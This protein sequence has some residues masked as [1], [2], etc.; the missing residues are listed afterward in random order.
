MKL[1]K[2]S[3]CAE[4][5][6]DKGDFAAKIIEIVRPAKLHLIDP[7]VYFNDPRYSDSIYGG[8]HG[9]NQETMDA[10]FQDVER[11]FSD[12]ISAQQ[13]VVHRM[14]SSEAVSS[15]P[16]RYFDW[17][18]IDANHLYEYVK[19][20]LEQYARKVKPNGYILGDDYKTPGWWEDGVTRAVDEFVKQSNLKLTV[21]K[22]QFRI[23]L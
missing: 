3:V 1:P 23:H 21:V 16:D 2:R 4:I 19:Q 7:W 17:I 5:G 8:D 11:R 13:V 15:F 22:H 12:R 9:Q 6:V 20:D 18:Y 10:R 14:S